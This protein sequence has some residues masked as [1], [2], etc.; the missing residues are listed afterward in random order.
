MPQITIKGLTDQQMRRISTPLF[1][2][3]A[4]AIGCPEDWL[5]LELSHSTF[6]GKG[7]PV[8]GF[9]IAVVS[10][11]DRPE[12]VRQRVAEILRARIMGEGFGLVQVIF[13]TLDTDRFFEFEE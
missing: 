11:F 5:I 1:T 13:Q 4:E 7:E 8:P 6:Y 3:L 12:K 9:P 2:E 10:W